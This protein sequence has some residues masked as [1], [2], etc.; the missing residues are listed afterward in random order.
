VL[1]FLEKERERER[2]RKR[3]RD[4]ETLLFLTYC[5]RFT[6]ASMA[7]NNT[8]IEFG[9]SDGQCGERERKRER[10]RGELKGEGGSFQW[11]LIIAY[12]VLTERSK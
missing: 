12:A 6:V 8:P 7:H 5:R 1:F 9:F 4:R 2:E 10:E 11:T 3:E